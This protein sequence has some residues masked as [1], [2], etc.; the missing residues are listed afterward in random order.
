[1]NDSRPVIALNKSVFKINT[2]EFFGL[3]ECLGNIPIPST[4]T[5]GAPLTTILWINKNDII[6]ILGKDVIYSLLNWNYNVHIPEQYELVKKALVDCKAERMK[7]KAMKEI[8]S[9]ANELYSRKHM[10]VHRAKRSS[11]SIVDSKWKKVFTSSEAKRKRIM[12]FQR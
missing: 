12:F 4:L 6:S 1:M 5:S 11:K 3:H 2:L 7:A 9:K 10:S 8:T